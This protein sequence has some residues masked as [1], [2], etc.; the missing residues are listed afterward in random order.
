MKTYILI[1]YLVTNAPY[2]TAVTNQT[3]GNYT[4]A[5]CHRVGE[6]LKATFTDKYTSMKYFCAPHFRT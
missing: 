1:Y 4:Q 6:N 5:E 3:D 2:P